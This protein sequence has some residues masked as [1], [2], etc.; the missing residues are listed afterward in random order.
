MIVGQKIPSIEEENQGFDDPHASPYQN[1][2]S[3]SG[4]RMHINLFQMNHRG[5][6]RLEY[7]RIF[8]TATYTLMGHGA[9]LESNK[10]SVLFTEIKPILKNRLAELDTRHGLQLS[11]RGVVTLGSTLT[12]YLANQGN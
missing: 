1:L 5:D 8:P 12:T 2:V 6:P 10:V 3:E 7:S 11:I 4:G 9:K